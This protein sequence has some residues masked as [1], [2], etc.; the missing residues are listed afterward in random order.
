MNLLSGIGKIK[1]V[2]KKELTKEKEILS[3]P[4][5]EKIYIPLIIGTSLDFE[6]HVEDGE[7]V[8]KGT[9]LATRK[10]LYVP[11]YSPISGIVK[12]IEKRMHTS[13][14]VQNHLVIENDF[15]CKETISFSYENVDK[16]TREELVSAMKEIGILGLGGSG[17]PTYVKYENAKDIDVVLIN[18]VECEPYLT[19]DYKIM[20]K[21]AKELV[22]GTNLLVKAA[23]SKKGIIAL[24][25]TNFNLLDKLKKEAEK[26][27][28]I[29]II[30]VPDAYPMG[31]ERVLIRE[32]FKKEY[33]RFPSEIG[34]I[35]NNAT[36]A[37][38]F[39]EAL[40]EKRAITHRIVTV[41]GEGIKN[42][43]NVYVPIGTSVD[44]I[45]EKIG[46]Y[47]EKYDELVVMG[48]GP[49]MG[50]SIANDKFVISSYSNSITVL[51]KEEIKELPCLRCG[52]CVEYCPAK[53]QPVQIMNAEKLK[54]LEK[55]EKACADKCIT[56][57]LCTFICPSKIEVTD[58]VGKAKDR[59]LKSRK[60]GK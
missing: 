10:D 25:V 18:A 44:Y 24:K 2:G 15:E 26:Y 22:D 14:K 23:D 32:I 17:F 34:I 20:K 19:S 41:S 56:C 58:W 35:V 59:V 16:L 39:S 43:E 13:G 5:P 47:N 49:M 55:S 51:P 37:I 53:I 8:K 42:Q 36:T 60:A 29:E 4:E 46:G 11:L 6:V 40:R 57:G 38:Y 7:Y 48:G 33:D 28:N 27:E 12:G 3:I 21:H 9:K 1:L 45:I 50:K 31:W 52:L 30:G 54:D